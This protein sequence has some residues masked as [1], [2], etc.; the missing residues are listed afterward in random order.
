MNLITDEEREAVQWMA[1]MC[2]AHL[3][4]RRPAVVALLCRAP[5][6]RDKAAAVVARLR[7]ASGYA[8]MDNARCTVLEAADIIEAMIQ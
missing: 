7:T 6:D 3:E 2:A 4:H 8:L 1:T 5:I